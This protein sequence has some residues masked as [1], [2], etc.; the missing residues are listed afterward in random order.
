MGGKDNNLGKMT[1]LGAACRCAQCVVLFVSFKP[2][3]ARGHRCRVLQQN[4]QARRGAP[5]CGG[6]TEGWWCVQGRG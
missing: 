3:K 4:P 6:P 2:V 1:E 5:K